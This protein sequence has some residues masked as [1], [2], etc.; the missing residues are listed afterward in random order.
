MED[1]SMLLAR[2]RLFRSSRRIFQ[3]IRQVENEAREKSPLCGGEN[4]F[5]Y[6][7]NFLE[8]R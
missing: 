1:D 3:R 5:T 7:G 8:R 4:F 6:A 2:E